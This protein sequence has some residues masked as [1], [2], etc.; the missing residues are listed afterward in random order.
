MDQSLRVRLEPSRIET[1][2]PLLIAGLRG[3]YTAEIMTGI[4]A[5]WRRSGRVRRI[6]YGVC[7]NR[8]TGADG[9]DYLS[10]FEVPS[11]SGVPDHWS[12]VSIPA[13]KY[14]VFPHRD[15]V[16][17]LRHTIDAIRREW[18]PGSGQELA[19]TAAGAPDLLER[20]GEQFDPR[21]GTGDMEVWV[22][23]KA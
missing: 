4:V 6:H 17:W 1:G 9:F 13:R 21:T 20:Y 19:H 15:H 22:P 11:F 5:Q 16:S 2:R 7:F 18:L 12:R 3:Y 14:L 10:G 23:I 8:L